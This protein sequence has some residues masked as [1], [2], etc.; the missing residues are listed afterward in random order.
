MSSLVRNRVL[1]RMGKVDEQV[2]LRCIEERS[3]RILDDAFIERLW[4]KF[5]EEKKN[6]YLSKLLG[7]NPI[8]SRLNRKG[9]IVKYLYFKKSLAATYNMFCTEAHGHV[10]ET[11]FEK[12]RANWNCRKC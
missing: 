1:I 5:C 12:L 11:I 6:F 9:R 2:F 7:H 3:V 8:V 10:L 4:V